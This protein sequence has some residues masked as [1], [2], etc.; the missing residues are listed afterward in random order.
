MLKPPLLVYQDWL[1]Q[2]RI[3]PDAAQENA[4]RTLSDLWLAITQ[5]GEQKPGFLGRLRR[6]DRIL[7]LYIHGE[8]GRGK[9]TL[10][11]LFYDHLPPMP[12][13]RVHFHAFMQQVHRELQAMRQA[14]EGENPLPKLAKRLAKGA[15]VLCFDEF[16]V[17]DIT[18]AMLLKGLFAPLFEENVV[19]VATSNW[20]PDDL[21]KDGLQRE[22]FVP[23]IP[24][25]KE[26]CRVL[27]LNSPHDY[28]LQ[29][30]GGRDLY[31]APANAETSR[32]L[33]EIF[34][35]FSQGQPVK[36]E[37]LSV[38]GRE[39]GIARAAGGA[40]WCDF[41]ELCG[42]PLGAADYL[43]LAE[44][45]HSLVLENIPVF[46]DSNM[47]QGKRFQTLVDV[48]YESETNLA[49]SAAAEPRE[50]CQAP[51]LAFSF[52]RTVSRLTEMRGWAREGFIEP[53]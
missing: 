1:A 46:M 33:G 9:T 51:A 10:M 35:R 14:G 39:L 52:Q 32:Q 26:H 36:P 44:F 21:Y 2:G 22:R 16:H 20:P 27:N 50:L 3:K 38:H 8:V 4:V 37:T 47:D 7:G 41:M 24:L 49:C 30:L 13:R 53:A 48:L 19:V 5:R 6:P 11:D 18:D 42:Q 15:R 43:E 34:T 25:L 29:Q 28:R 40:A 31:L 17:T 23:F 45:F 12:K